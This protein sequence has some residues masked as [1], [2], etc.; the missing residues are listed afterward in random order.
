MTPQ[1]FVFI[2]RSGCGKGTQADLLAKR[3]AE[4]DAQSPVFYLETGQKFRDFT[5]KS[6]YSNSL[7]KAIQDEGA[8]QPSFLAVWIWADILIE[9]LTG[10]EHLIIDGTPRKLGEA[11]IFSDAMKFF[12][13][14]PHIIYLNVSRKWSET[15]LSE[16]HR[17]DDALATVKRRLDWFDTNVMPAVE[18]FSTNLD[19]HFHDVNGERSVEEIQKEIREKVGLK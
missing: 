10:N 15:R 16:R 2:G 8:L 7:A 5:T 14:T 6:G 13:R 12:S 19:V 3:L 1:T 4:V 17:S 18:Y 9:K 11:I